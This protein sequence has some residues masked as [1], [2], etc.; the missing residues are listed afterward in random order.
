LRGDGHRDKT[1]GGDSEH[2]ETEPLPPPRN[3]GDR[4]DAQSPERDEN[5]DRVDDEG[6]DG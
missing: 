2:G 1:G 6:M 3:D 4:H 5:D